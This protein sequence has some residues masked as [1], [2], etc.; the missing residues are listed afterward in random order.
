MRIAPG[1]FGIER[2]KAWF[3]GYAYDWHR[4]DTY[5]VGVTLEGVQT[6]DCRRTTHD[7]LAGQVMVLHP[8]EPHNGRA[9]S[10][11]GFGYCMMY[12]EPSR[13]REALNLH[14][15]PFVPQM[16]FTDRELAPTILAAFR[17]FPQPLLELESDAIIAHVADHLRQRSDARPGQRKPT[18]AKR[19]M[20][21]V[22]AFLDAEFRR[23][24]SSSDL[25]ALTGL[26]RY[27]I[28]RHFRLLYGTSPYRYLMMRRL[29]EAKRQIVQGTPIVT[30]AIDL[31]F[32]D[33]SHLTRCFHQMFGLPPG[34]LQRLCGSTK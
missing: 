28:A 31:G 11:T 24:V 30:A 1:L 27:A 16:V 8:D 15:L 19:L 26:D 9:G 17:S 13:I 34:R 2:L 22:R 12:L 5:A 4:H 32:A 25:E 20:E 23:S 33:Q 3:H 7:S 29:T 6:F 21:R 10:R 14:D 18:V